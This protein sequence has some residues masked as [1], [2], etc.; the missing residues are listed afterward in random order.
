MQTDHRPLVPIFSKPIHNA[1]KRLQRMLLRLQK[2]ALKLCY[3]PGKEMYVADMLSQAYLHEQPSREEDHQLFQMSQEAQVYKEIK[4]IDPAK[5]VRLSAQGLENIREATSQDDTL[6]ELAKIIQQGW[7]DLKQNVPMSIRAFWPYRDELVVDNNVVFKGTKVVILKSM[8]A[9]MLQ[10]SHIS[11]QGPEACVRR[12]RHAI[13]WPGM[14]SE[15]RHL[16]SQ[17]STCSDYNTKQQ[18]EPLLSTEIPTMPWAILAQDLFTLAG[19]SYL[20][21]VHY[22]SDFWELDIQTDTFSENIVKHTK[23]HFARYGI[24]EKVITDNGPQFRAQSYEECIAVGIQ[25]CHKFTILQSR[26]WQG[27]SNCKNCKKYAEESKPRQPG[28][29]PCNTCM[30][31]YAQYKSFNHEEHVHNYQL[32]GNC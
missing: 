10:R 2:Y 14:A 9:L 21:T 1:P 29:K 25:S 8:H 13:F 7:P 30:A 28:H 11:H 19:K 3:C 12:A 31:Q 17:C 15:I 20:I 32:S 16:A 5:H 26:Q 27:R 4:E 23:A 18:K 24:P 22:Y 6:N